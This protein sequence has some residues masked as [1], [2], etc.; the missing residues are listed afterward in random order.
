M[1]LKYIG[2]E[3]CTAKILYA[4][5]NNF[6]SVWIEV[7][8]IPF[9]GEYYIQISKYNKKGLWKFYNVAKV[10]PKQHSSKKVCGPEESHCEKD[11]KSKVAAK[12]RL[13]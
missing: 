9:Y 11:V 6:K 12:K 8:S 2:K 4:N 13:W 7:S 10:I 5:F 1:P 3:T